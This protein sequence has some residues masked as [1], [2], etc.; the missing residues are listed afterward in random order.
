MTLSGCPPRQS[1]LGAH[2]HKGGK[3]VETYMASRQTFK[4]C[5]RIKSLGPKNNEMKKRKKRQTKVC[6]EQELLTNFNGD[7]SLLK[8]AR[9]H[10]F[11][12]CYSRNSGVSSLSYIIACLK[13]ISGLQ[14]N[15]KL[16]VILRLIYP[17]SETITLKIFK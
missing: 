16:K 11:S 1:V 17:Y 4:I 12:A 6:L 8:S 2:T 10:I 13:S 3:A 5:L 9:C 14:E 7:S 15:G